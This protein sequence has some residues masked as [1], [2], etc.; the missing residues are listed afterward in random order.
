MANYPIPAKATLVRIF[1]LIKLSV[2]A[3]FAGAGFC[4]AVGVAAPEGATYKSFAPKK[5]L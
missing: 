1:S 5:S 2:R 4:G 3:G